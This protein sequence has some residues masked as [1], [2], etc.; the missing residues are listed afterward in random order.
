MAAE[1]VGS[2][3][4]DLALQMHSLSNA[5]STQGIAQIIPPFD[6]TPSKYKEW[7]R[8]V[9]KYAYLV[10]VPEDRVKLVAFQ[11]AKGCVSSFLQRFL[12]DH[13]DAS[14][15]DVKAELATR[16]AEI[17]DCQHAFSLLRNVKQ[18][19]DESV[20]MYG[21][22][23]LSLAAEAYV[24]QPGGL[25]GVERQLVGYFI[26]GLFHDYL[27]MKVMRDNPV[28]LQ[29]AVTSAMAEQNLRKR[30]ELR[31]KPLKKH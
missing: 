25:Q 16:F 24:G 1:N 10:K 23:L 28:N 21:E 13:G 3:F 27:K 9:E 4:Q 8:N 31:S 29:A 22:R 20:Q 18:R 14:W 30:F 26:D 5:L 15:E 12:S 6:G 17:T 7:V 2:V 19:R 11:T